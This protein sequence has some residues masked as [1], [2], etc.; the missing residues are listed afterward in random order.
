L[1]RTEIKLYRE[2]DFK[3]RLCTAELKRL[4]GGKKRKFGINNF[5]DRKSALILFFFLGRNITGFAGAGIFEA[6]LK[7]IFINS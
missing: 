1:F 3:A 2:R 6:S 4:K 7:S 5:C